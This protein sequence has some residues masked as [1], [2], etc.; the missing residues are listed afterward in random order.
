MILKPIH[1]STPISVELRIPGDKSLSH[2][3]LMFNA[4]AV[5]TARVSNLLMGEDVLSTL[6]ILQQLGVAIS[7]D[8]NKV[9]TI[10]GSAGRFIQPSGD[11]DCGN[12]GT[13]MRLM[14][15]LLS[16]S[17]LEVVLTGDASLRKRPMARV[18][19]YLQDLGVE[20]PNGYEFAPLTQKGIVTIPYFEAHLH[21]ASAQMKSALLL[22]G[23]QGNG[24]IVRGGAR[25]RDHSE[26]LLHSMGA[27]IVH[28]GE[29][30]V[31][32]NKA[33]LK[34]IDVVVPND[35]SSAAFFVVA[36]LLLKDSTIVMRN[37]GLNPTRSGLLTVLQQMGGNIEIVD[38]RLMGGEP[39]GDLVVRSSQLHG[40]TLTREII[41]TMIDEIPILAL[42]A[43][44]AYGTTVIRHAKD[45]RKKESDRI[46]TIVQTFSALGIEVTEY[47]DGL[48]VIGPQSIKGGQVQ[49]LNDHRIV[50]TCSIASLVSEGPI[51]IDSVEAVSTSFPSFWD[52][53]E[54]LHA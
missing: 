11:L 22:A 25:S 51:S 52:L 12:S 26:R 34:A 30:D 53:F 27:N 54:T 16:A 1:K 35:V 10:Q 40:T 41:P 43:S 33:V 24:C 5:G 46:S 42:A 38:N 14:L 48:S 28:L 4:L 39:V 6:K 47:E 17:P 19:T 50:M 2:R 32:I 29:G 49:C 15:G 44:Q 8:A 31:Q 21:I 45:L 20:Y 7:F 18:T 37:I 13:T 36:G 3:A 23:V 9:L